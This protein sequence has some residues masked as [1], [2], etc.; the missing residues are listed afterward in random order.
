MKFC[1]TCWMPLEKAE[2][3]GAHKEDV[4]LYLLR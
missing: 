1:A 3:I 4:F 2:F